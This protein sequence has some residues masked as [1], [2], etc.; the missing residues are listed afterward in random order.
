HART[1]EQRVR[2]AV[3]DRSRTLPT[4]QRLQRVHVVEEELPK[5]ALG[6]VDRPRVKHDLL[7]RLRA[8]RS[9]GVS[10]PGGHEHEPPARNGTHNGGQH[11]LEEGM[12]AL[13]SRLSGVP[14]SQVGPR[15]DLEA[16]LRLDSLSKV[17]LLL[18]LETHYQVPL[19]ESLGPSLH[20]FG[21]VLEAVRQ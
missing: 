14:R 21:D 12:R 9:A 20:T 5:S 19:P 18:A 7:Q 2:Q 3:Q 17:E 4:Y 11:A 16:D 6:V 13:V 15:S 10:V 8:S 1:F